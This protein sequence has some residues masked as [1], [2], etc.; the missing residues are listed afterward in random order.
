MDQ[1]QPFGRL[2]FARV[3]NPR[4]VTD[5][6]LRVVRI[7]VVLIATAYYLLLTSPAYAHTRVEIGPYVVVVGWR[8]EPVVAGERNALVFEF[9]EEE[10]PVS[11]AEAALDAEVSYGGR[12]TSVNLTPTE[13]PGLY[14]AELYPTVRGQY[15]VRLS[16]TLGETAVDEVIEPEE[17]L[18]AA[19]LQFPEPL[20]DTLSLQQRIA[21]LETQMQTA[22]TV[23]F[24]AAGV[25]LL[26]LILAA[27]GLL[28]K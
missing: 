21:A 13:T 11:G 28:R 22:R 24:V 5:C 18:P 19:Q 2:L 3:S 16:G 1:I 9:S 14:T 20:P 27:V 10:Q 17:V 8:N 15:S 25:G 12:M 7:A 23:A 6:L 4:Y 26:G